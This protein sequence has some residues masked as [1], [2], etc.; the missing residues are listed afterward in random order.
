MNSV[1]F[2]TQGEVIQFVFDAL[3][4]MPRKHE[5]DPSFDET[6]KKSTQKA[7]QRLAVEE[8]VLDQR[9]GEMIQ[10]LSYLVAGSIPPRESL[11]LGD[12]LCDLFDIYRDTLRT[13]GTF[14]TKLESVKWILMDRVVQRLPISIVKHL[15][16]YNVAADSLIVPTD[17]Y[18][19]LPSRGVDGWLW[20]LEKVMRWAYELAG[21]SIKRFHWPEDCQTQE[22]NFESA[23]KWLADIHV[24]S[25]PALLMNFNQSFDALGRTQVEQGLPTLSDAQKDSIRMALFVARVSTYI[26]K[27]ILIHLDNESLNEACLRYQ[28]IAD[29]VEDDKQRV[30][31]C[32]QQIIVRKGISSNEL[33]QLWFDVST[34]YWVQFAYRQNSILQGLKHNKISEVQAVKMLQSLGRLRQLSFEKPEIFKPV[35]SIPPGFSKAVLDGLALRK[36]ADINTEKIEA[37]AKSLDE[38]NLHHVLEWMVPWQMAT[39]HYCAGRY[40]AAYPFIKDAFEKAQYCAG[41]HQYLLVNQYI[42]LAAKNDKRRDFKR[43]IEWA[44]YLGI[45]IRWLR[46]DEPTQEKLQF[47]YEIM[48]KAVYVV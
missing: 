29:C 33:D 9:L 28:T 38:K 27:K 1:S 3:G 31:R 26:S 16:R 44:T 13:E 48:K 45:E 21:T 39:C 6:H 37:Y 15:Q 10:T 11:A 36:S 43:G 41:S 42:E 12:I 32:V 34:D 5:D 24:P 18:W 2:P 7:L 47:V 8:G 4:I 22:K 25:W 23:K 19:Y 30:N 17:I 46:K 20:P 14:L 35:Y 40:E